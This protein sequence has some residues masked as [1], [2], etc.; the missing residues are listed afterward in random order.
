MGQLIPDTTDEPRK[1]SMNMAMGQLFGETG[2]TY[3]SSLK[4]REA[5][6]IGKDVALV[7][8][9]PDPTVVVSATIVDDI[10]EKR[11]CPVC[12]K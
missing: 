4:G 6:S 7:R 12:H 10:L 1:R 2:K 9:G 8:R 11:G 5:S 3:D